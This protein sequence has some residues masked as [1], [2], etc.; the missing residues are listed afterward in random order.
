MPTAPELMALSRL[1]PGTSLLLDCC[2]RAL[3][4][5]SNPRTQAPLHAAQCTVVASKCL[6]AHFSEDPSAVA[7]IEAA[8]DRLLGQG[9]ALVGLASRWPDHELVVREYQRL[10]EG[11]HEWTEL[12][13]CVDLW[14]VSAQGTREQVASILAQ[15]VTRREQ[16]PWDFPEDALDAFRARLERD[17]EV[18]ET[19]AQFARENDEPSVRASIARLLS[20]ASTSQS[21]GLAEELLTAECRRSGPPR[22]ALDI[23]TNRIQPAGALMRE[24][25]AA[26]S[27]TLPNDS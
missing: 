4:V 3:A 16:S 14:L 20:S 23:L 8:S 17:P 21:H 22:F 26:S 2:R 19:F 12:L 9:A 10:L 6:A 5:Q 13:F 24:A 11:R 18:E 15:F 27:S 7:A 25:L 1:R